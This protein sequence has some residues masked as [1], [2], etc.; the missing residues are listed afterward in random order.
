M[1]LIKSVMLEYQGKD[2]VGESFWG[3]STTQ[4]R[5]VCEYCKVRGS[6]LCG[7]DRL[8]RKGGGDFNCSQLC[9]YTGDNYKD[10]SRLGYYYSVRPFDGD[11]HPMDD[12][13]KKLCTRIKRPRSKQSPEEAELVE[14]LLG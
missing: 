3:K 9:P 13:V 14:T 8:I 10:D 4:D 1:E 5:S 11:L 2:Y 7:S 12:T 6:D